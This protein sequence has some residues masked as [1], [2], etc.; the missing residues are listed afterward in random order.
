MSKCH[1]SAAWVRPSGVEKLTMLYPELAV[2]LVRWNLQASDPAS[3]VGQG[4]G[5]RVVQDQGQGWQILA[6]EDTL[7]RALG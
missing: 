2:V 4:M 7:I 5:L 1:A 6:P 3:V